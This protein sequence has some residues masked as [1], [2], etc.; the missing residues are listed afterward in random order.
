MVASSTDIQH[1]NGDVTVSNWPRAISK[2]SK[3]LNQG[4]GSKMAWAII[5]F[6][7]LK[8]NFCVKYGT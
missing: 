4:M 2:L 5:P 3:I 8:I 7:I 6:R 1:S